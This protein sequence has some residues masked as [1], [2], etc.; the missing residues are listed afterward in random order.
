MGQNTFRLWF[1]RRGEEAAARFLMKMGFSILERN[2]R[3]RFGEIDL[4]ARAGELLVFVEVKARTDGRFGSGPEAVDRRK[5]TR[6]QK[7]ALHYLATY[8]G[9]EPLIRFDV[10]AVD[11]NGRC[12]HIEDAFFFHDDMC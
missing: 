11:A 7:T 8:P 1:G 3:C 12:S 6:I 10:I 9:P 4:I 5:Q 2:H